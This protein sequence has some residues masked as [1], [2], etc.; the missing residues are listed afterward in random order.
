ML[1]RK[2]V[3]KRMAAK[4]REVK[5]SLMARRHLPI[6][7]QGRWLASVVRGHLAYYAVPGNIDMVMA[8]RTQATRHWCRALRR[9]S[10]RHRLDWERIN[11]LSTR[12]LPPARI[13]TPGPTRASTPEPKAGAQ[14]V[15][16]ARWDL[17]GGPP[18]TAV[19]TAIKLFGV[20]SLIAQP[21][22]PVQLGPEPRAALP[23]APYV[24]LLVV[25]SQVTTTQC[26]CAGPP[27]VIAST[28]QV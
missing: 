6:P 21:R 28:T 12:W 1:K 23:E 20:H 24:P 19:P 25:Y 15:S 5:T 16:S 18:A 14:C 9:R 8:F 17:R 7:D 22:P 10:Q 4:L 2:T 3:S 27:A 11:R 13:S 26:R